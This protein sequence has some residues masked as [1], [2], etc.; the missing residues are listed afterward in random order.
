MHCANIIKVSKWVSSLTARCSEYHAL[1]LVCYKYAVKAAIRPWAPILC[2]DLRSEENRVS[3]DEGANAHAPNYTR[4]HRELSKYWIFMWTYLC[5]SE[6]VGDGKCCASL[7]NNRAVMHSGTPGW[8]H[9]DTVGHFHLFELD[10]HTSWLIYA[11]FM[12]Y[13]PNK[14][15]DCGF[16]VTHHCRLLH[17]RYSIH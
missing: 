2:N 10:M 14:K 7:K 8:Y 4:D 17:V 11:W 16:S 1:S 15:S 13:I 3:G 6:R 12:C 9:E 5:A